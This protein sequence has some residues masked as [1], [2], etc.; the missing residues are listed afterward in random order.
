MKYILSAALALCLMPAAQAATLTVLAAASTTDAMRETA[1]LFSEQTGHDVRF[2]FASS[3]ALARQIQSGA[4]ADLFLSAN[5][6]WMEALGGEVDSP[7]VLFKNRLVMVVPAGR[8]ADR[9]NRLA[10]GDIRSVPLGMYAK[11]ALET[12]GRFDE[13][14]P[15]MV[16]TAN[17]RVALMFVELGEV[18][19]GIVY[20][21]DAKAS[22]RV[23]VAS[24]FPEES[25]SPIIYPA[26]VCRTSGNPGL[27]REFL[28]FLQ[29]DE[30][31]AVFNKYG[32][33][34]GLPP[35]GE[36]RPK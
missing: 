11:E 23:S 3:G 27:A 20:A 36:E 2:S 7:V 17:A 24:V 15:K 10:V 19:A 21:T 34:A 35:P 4:P 13:L 8:S 29:S 31:D 22:S 12:S 16:M 18:D 14:Y 28:A 9:V 6:R 5:T 33:S 32:F 1:A 26:A 25:H 30:A